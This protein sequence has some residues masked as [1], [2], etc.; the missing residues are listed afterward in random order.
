MVDSL[1]DRAILAREDARGAW[2]DVLRRIEHGAPAAFLYAQTYVF[3][4]HRRFRD[5]AIRPQSSWMS[6]WRWNLG[7]MPAASPAGS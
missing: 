1:L 4:V 3:V 2:H 7:G 6:I 5:V